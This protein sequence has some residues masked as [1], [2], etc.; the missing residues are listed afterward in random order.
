MPGF[1]AGG[2][3]TDDGIPVFAQLPYAHSD[4][5]TKFFGYMYTCPPGSSTHIETLDYKVRFQGIIYWVKNP[6][7][8]DTLSL[9]IIDVDNVL[10]RGANLNLNEYIKDYYVPPWNHQAEIQAAT[11]E[12]IEAGISAKISY[13][14]AGQENVTLGITYRCLE[15]V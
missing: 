15:C 1:I 4:E 13:F 7:A 14:N 9:S 12:T 11:A 5:K 6:T 10:A 3:R 2:V 8:G